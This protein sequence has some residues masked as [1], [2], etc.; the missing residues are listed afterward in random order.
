MAR[1]WYHTCV[2]ENK[3]TWSGTRVLEASREAKDTDC[4]TLLRNHDDCEERRAEL[5]QSIGSVC[6]CDGGEASGLMP[7]QRRVS[8]EK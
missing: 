1:R 8:S 3:S 5:L 6:L 2:D 7:L 4:A